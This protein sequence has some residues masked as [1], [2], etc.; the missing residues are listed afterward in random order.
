M[1]DPRSDFAAIVSRL[2]RSGYTMNDT[3]DLFQQV[4][5]HFYQPNL[6]PHQIEAIRKPGANRTAAEIIERLEA[7]CLTQK[8]FGKPP[9]QQKTHMSLDVLTNKSLRHG[10]IVYANDLDKNEFFEHAQEAV[11]CNSSNHNKG[12][13]LQYVPQYDRDDGTAVVKLV[14]QK[15][16]A[17]P[18]GNGK[19][20]D[21]K[22]RSATLISQGLQEGAEKLS[23]ALETLFDVRS[24]VSVQIHTASPVRYNARNQFLRDGVEL[25]DATRLWD[26]VWTEE[27]K[28]AL[29]N[30]H[31]A[32]RAKGFGVVL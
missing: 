13:D 31:G 14:Q 21:N 30:C 28:N 25:Y 3:N 26:E 27:V 15:V 24:R 23:A 2:Q 11:F 18:I 16:G 10:H 19:T 1:Q 32:Q 9:P 22:N 4:L 8:V 7:D 6:Q 5:G 20:A 29:I 12:Y 17:T